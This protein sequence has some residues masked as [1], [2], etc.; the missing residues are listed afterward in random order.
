MVTMAM[1]SSV[2]GG[3]WAGAEFP[4]SNPECNNFPYGFGDI[5]AIFALFEGGVLEHSVRSEKDISSDWTQRHSV[6]SNSPR[7][8]HLSRQE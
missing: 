8:S 4:I 5:L 3:K 1:Y 6:P 7:Y 2:E